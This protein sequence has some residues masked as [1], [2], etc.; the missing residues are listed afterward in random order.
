[1]KNNNKTTFIIVSGILVLVVFTFV[2][3][4][5]ILPKITSSDSYF[6]KVEDDMS[7]KVEALEIKNGKMTVITSGDAIEYCVKSTKSTPTDNALCWKKIENN[8]AT[9]SVYDYE[10]YYIWI[11]NIE[12][13]VSSPMS[14]NTND[15]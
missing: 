10:K 7:A 13:K 5:N 4:I 6:V 9:I 15:N 2:A 1:M 14:V 12:G 3:T 11:K 8:K